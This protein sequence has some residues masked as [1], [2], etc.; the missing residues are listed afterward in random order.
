MKCSFYSTSTLHGGRTPQRMMFRNQIANSAILKQ[1]TVVIRPFGYFP[2]KMISHKDKNELNESSLW[3][4]SS[5]FFT[6]Y[7]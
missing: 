4:I 6:K 2:V 3:V 1:R 7:F 5:F